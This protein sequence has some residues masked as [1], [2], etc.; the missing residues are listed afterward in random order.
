MSARARA[1]ADPRAGFTL[2][3]LL[4]AMVVFSFVCV[5]IYGVLV[6]G[7]KSASSGERVA[8]QS[9]RYRVATELMT[10][11]LAGAV[12]IQLPRPDQEGFGADKD[13]SGPQRYFFGESDQI[14]FVTTSPQ[15]PDAS[16][17]AIVRYWLEDGTIRMSETPTYAA[18]A[19]GDELGGA[20][21]LT[22]G[23][24]ATLMY[25]V[26]S[27]KLSY[28]RDPE[29]DE[30]LDEWNAEDEDN[31]PAVVRLEVTPSV[32]AGPSWYEEAPILVS[33]FNQIND[34]S[35]YEGTGKSQGSDNSDD[36]DPGSGSGGNGKNRGKGGGNQNSSADD[37]PDD[38]SPPSTLDSND[39]D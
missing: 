26:D 14:E 38:A 27:L 1:G 10:R 18:Y 32:A 23:I 20:K 9:R 19:K 33:A 21:G 7:A 30:W 36:S 8:E 6:L 16:G 24:E 2:L 17:L 5:G 31:M 11:Q 3:E 25:D 34:E 28:Q 15:R 4:V 29:N 39:D 13:E 22:G 35:D 37:S 12:P